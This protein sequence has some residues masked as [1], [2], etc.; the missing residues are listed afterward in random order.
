[1][2]EGGVN[3]LRISTHLYNMP[4]EVDRALEAIK[5]AYKG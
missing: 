1:V 2:G 5:S 4:E 3:A